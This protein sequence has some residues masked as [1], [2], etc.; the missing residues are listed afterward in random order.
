MYLCSFRKKLF[1]RLFRIYLNK[2]FGATGRFSLFEM[3]DAFFNFFIGV[4]FKKLQDARRGF[5]IRY[6]L[7]E[8]VIEELA[9]FKF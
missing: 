5:D 6:K 1:I 8:R 3:F 9:L 2:K 4:L 7:L